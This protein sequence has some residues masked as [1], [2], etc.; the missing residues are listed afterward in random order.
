MKTQFIN[1]LFLHENFIV[2]KL[3]F[4]NQDVKEVREN[5]NLLLGSVCRNRLDLEVVDQK[6][7]I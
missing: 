6:V 5:H 4:S 2:M 3:Y 1:V 7:N